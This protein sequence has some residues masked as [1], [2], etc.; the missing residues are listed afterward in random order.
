MRSTFL[1]LLCCLSFLHSW[2]AQVSF[3]G[4]AACQL[5]QCPGAVLANRTVT[6]DTTRV[7]SRLKA[8]YRSQAIPYAGKK[9][10]TQRHRGEWAETAQAAWAVASR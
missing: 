5:L 3:F 8:I 9:L 1:L 4:Q 10:Y 7:M 6:V 2:L